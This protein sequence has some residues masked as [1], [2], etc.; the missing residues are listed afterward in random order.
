MQANKRPGRESFKARM[1]RMQKEEPERYQQMQERRGAFHRALAASDPIDLYLILNTSGSGNTIQLYDPGN[2]ANISPNTTNTAPI[3]STEVATDSSN[4][5][6]RFFVV[7]LVSVAH[8]APPLVVLM[9]SP[10]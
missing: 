1:A 7:T 9:T 10:P 8:S 2:K 6:W 3:S 5:D 4:Y